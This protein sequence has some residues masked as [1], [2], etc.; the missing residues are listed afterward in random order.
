MNT[1]LVIGISVPIFVIGA[2]L[3]FGPKGE[4]AQEIEFRYSPVER[5]DISRS[6]SATGQVVALTSVDVKSK[7]GGNVVKL[8]VDEGSVVKKGDLIAIIDPSDTQSS[9]DQAEADLQSSSARATQASDNLKL[10]IDQSKNEVADAEVALQTAKIRLQR[11]QIQAGRQ[12]ELTKASLEAAKAALDA[13]KADLNRID[14]VTIPQ[15]RRDA[16]VNYQQAK[17]QLDAAKADINRQM[18][19]REKGFVSDAAVEKARSTAES[20]NAAYETAAQRRRTIENDVRVS[21][22][23]ARLSVAKA[24]ANYEQAV[25]SQTDVEVQ[26]TN[27]DEAKRA[28]KQAEVALDKAKADQMLIQVRKSDVLAARASTVHGEVALKNAKVQLDST[29]VLAPRDGVVTQK[30]LEEGTIIPPGTSTFAQG[31]SLVQLSDVT[32]L[33]VECAVDE[34]D[35]SNVKKGQAVRITCDAYRGQPFDGIVE[36]VNPAAKTDN[37][38]TAVKVRVRVLPGAKIKVLP[39]MNATC[40][41]IT[42]RHTNVLTVPSQALTDD[43]KHVRVKTKD[44]LKPEVREVEVGE[45]GNDSVEIKS[46]LKEGEEVVTAE[47][48]MVELRATQ[49]KMKDAEQGGGLAGGNNGMQTK[50]QHATKDKNAK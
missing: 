35:I 1:K 36:R 13:A 5:G 14:Q 43:G 39:G 38:I 30:Y 2:F 15:Q 19:L 27:L 9:Y 41:F 31:T 4:Q 8:A 26:R 23:Q 17:A 42:M 16:Q 46:G 48:D 32:Q 6:I 34:A 20:A 10:Q 7:A 45:T 49:Q 21:E 11:A 28:Y 29:T 25:A 37:N 3:L 22:T 44:P 50:K 12:P 40:E 24:E 33:F 18:G 47:I